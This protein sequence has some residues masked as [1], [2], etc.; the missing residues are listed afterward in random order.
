MLSQD[1]NS[2][3]SVL[4]RLYVN[5]NYFRINEKTGVIICKK[6]W[7]SLKRHVTCVK[8]VI[9]DVIPQ[10]LARYS[11]TDSADYE[12]T[13]NAMYANKMAEHDILEK[14]TKTFFDFIRTYQF[15]GEEPT[16][17]WPY[18]LK[19]L[20]VPKF[21]K[22]KDKY[23]AF[24]DFLKDYIFHKKTKAKEKIA[25]NLTS[26]EEKVNETIAYVTRTV[27]QVC[28]GD[29]ELD[30]KYRTVIRYLSPQANVYC[31]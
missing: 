22:L 29:A 31:L 1:K 17:Q 19:R 15:V 23:L 30:E 4:K 9:V 25:A 8:E 24:K 18:T 2:L 20:K 14:V 28:T 12:M 16:V 21:K 13:I 10:G 26:V 11:G 7:Y 5:C 27:G 6:H 3:I